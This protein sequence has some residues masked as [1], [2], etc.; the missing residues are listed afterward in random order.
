LHGPNGPPGLHGVDGT[1]VL[2]GVTI[3][4]G[5]GGHLFP[6][7]GSMPSLAFAGAAPFFAGAAPFFAGAAPF[8]A[9][10]AAFLA[11]GFLAPFFGFPSSST[12]AN[13]FEAA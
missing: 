10:G 7:A 2:D 3:G 6:Q 1:L 8:L 9:A 4:A 13:G 11:S 12:N 5:I